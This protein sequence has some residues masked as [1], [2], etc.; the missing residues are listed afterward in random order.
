[1]ADFKENMYRRLRSA[2]QWL[3]RAEEAFD[4]DRDIRAELDLMLAQA[5]LQ[6]AKEAN[7][8]RHWRFK[9]SFLTQGAAIGLAMMFA[10]VGFGGTYWWYNQHQISQYSTPPVIQQQ[11]QL[12][13]PPAALS[14][15]PERPKVQEESAAVTVKPVSA[16]TTEK[17][18]LQQN[19]IAAETRV[20]NE[21][22]PHQAEKE[23]ALPPDE[24]QKLVRAAGKSLRGQ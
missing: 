18:V 14:S 12:P 4:K 15:A 19:S 22:Q 13:Q 21:E 20:K 17:S 7:R 2:R 5:E 24:M 8:T 3:M 23:V 1:M 9:Y 16:P 11:I 10:V 6:H